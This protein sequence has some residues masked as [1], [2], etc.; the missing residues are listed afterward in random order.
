[1]KSFPLIS[2]TLA[3]AAILSAL[4]VSARAEEAKVPYWASIRATEVNMRSGPGEDYRISWVYH[5]QHLPLK[6]LR[7]MEGWRFV[8]DPD[9]AQGWVMAR[10]L[11]RERTAFVSGKA[12]A[13][14]REAGSQSA[15]LQWRVEPGVVAML[16]DCDENWCAVTI[17][18]RRGYIA[19]RQLW[20]AGEP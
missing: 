18:E 5:R 8:Q 11:T 3:A 12:P 20:G 15:K 17:D 6:V 14:M 2:L 9:G 16:G 1:M 19:Q 13:D 4:P 10:F 7:T